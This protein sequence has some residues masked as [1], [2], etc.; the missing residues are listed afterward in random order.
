MGAE[1]VAGGARGPRPRGL[2]PLFLPG[3]LVAAGLT[4]WLLAPPPRPP[5]RAPLPL[6]PEPVPAEPAPASP[7]PGDLPGELEAELA[8]LAELAERPDGSRVPLVEG[9][10]PAGT[11]RLLDPDPSA[12]GRIFAASG[13]LAAFDVW[14]AA[15]GR[16]ETLDPRLVARLEEVD[17]AFRERDL[18][19]P[20]FPFLY[21]APDGRARPRDGALGPH[22]E[23][24][25]PGLPE[26]L[27]GWT[28]ALATRF[29]SAADALA[30][31][32]ASLGTGE[33]WAEGGEP[34]PKPRGFA[35]GLGLRFPDYLG[36][37][38]QDDG[39]R[40]AAGLWIRPG[41]EALQAVVYAAGR[42]LRADPGRAD[43]LALVAGAML[44]RLDGLWLDAF[45]FAP[46]AR[47]AGPA[48][49]TGAEWYL[50]AEVLRQVARARGRIGRVDPA[51]EAE[52]DGAWEKALEPGG[53]RT[54]PQVL[55][56]T[57]AAKKVLERRV[58]ARD[59]A[60]AGAFYRAQRGWLLAEEGSGALVDLLT[61]VA[62]LWVDRLDPAEP[63]LDEIEEL[64]GALHMGQEHWEAER[65]RARVGP[66][67][68]A[69]V[70]RLRAR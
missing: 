65:A 12:W 58:A 25:V 8:R 11:R 43:G 59:F 53:D 32:Q 14:I 46:P 55:R 62:R 33:P 54:P 26:T 39:T 68:E 3:L 6:G 50:R 34:A 44:D 51:L 60:G 15:G 47:L 21:L 70:A 10:P 5:R 23:D 61:E 63:G 45:A 40:A 30:R 49:G 7:F 13:A 17:R 41:S 66:L 36:T 57:Y 42:A 1:L 38:W 2:P 69:L 20:L 52:L 56:R 4:A 64:V 9:R 19:A 18:P 31:A 37:C 29:T 16:P 28:S 35:F 67:F 48:P 24:L 22:H 27:A